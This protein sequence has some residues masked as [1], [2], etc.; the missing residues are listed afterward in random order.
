MTQTPHICCDAILIWGLTVQGDGG[1]P[2]KASHLLP[3]VNL[4]LKPESA[5][6]IFKSAS[7]VDCPAAVLSGGHSLAEIAWG[8]FLFRAAMIPWLMEHPSSGSTLHDKGVFPP[9]PS[10]QIVSQ[11][12]GDPRPSLSW[13]CG[14]VSGAPR[15]PTGSCEW[16]SQPPL[17][18][19]G[20]AKATSPWWR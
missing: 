7:W 8:L 6:L 20:C 10:L 9:C 4:W 5:T 11:C 14:T 17:S 15:I 18:Q 2:R 1:L 16:S 12:W 19:S 3:K 13:L